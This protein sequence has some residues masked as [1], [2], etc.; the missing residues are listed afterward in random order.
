MVPPFPVLADLHPVLL[1]DL[2]ELQAGELA[3]LVGIE[4]LGPAPCQ[5]LNQGLGAK[6]RLRVLDNRQAAMYRLCQSIMATR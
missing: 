5:R 3:S 4:Y 2:G 1:G 6:A